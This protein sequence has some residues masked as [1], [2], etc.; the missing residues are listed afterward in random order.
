MGYC[1]TRL[2]PVRV[3]PVTAGY[4]PCG[5]G[6]GL[7]AS[8]AA[9]GDAFDVSGE[10]S[11]RR[12][13]G[14]RRLAPGAPRSQFARSSRE[15]A[16]RMQATSAFPSSCR[17]SATA[18]SGDPRGGAPTRRSSCAVARRHSSSLG[19][20]GRGARPA[21]R[22]RMRSARL[23]AASVQSSCARLSEAWHPATIWAR[24]AF[25]SEA[26]CSRAMSAATCSTS[27]SHSAAVTEDD[28]EAAGAGRSAGVRLLQAARASTT[29][30]QESRSRI[31]PLE[32]RCLALRLA[33][34]ELIDRT[35]GQR[36]ETL[37][38]RVLLVL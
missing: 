9:G 2:T 13:P 6:A 14:S 10:V 37:L 36:L 15:R 26:M 38:H 31:A 29:S 35:A 32:A 12:F 22:Q 17:H 23:C 4:G 16:A 3:R 27:C 28:F 30:P 7:A 11:G 34:A 21:P 1:P 20:P 5:L 18:A 19:A 8:A 24:V 25:P 33:G